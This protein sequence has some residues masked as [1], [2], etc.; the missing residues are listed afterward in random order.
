MNEGKSKMTRAQQ[1]KP[2][3]RIVSSKQFVA[4][5]EPPD[6]LIDG[7]VQRGFIYSMTAR[8]GDGKT[9]VALSIAAAIGTGSPLGDLKMDRGRVVYFAG[10]NPDDVRMRWIAMGERMKFDVNKIP[11]HFVAGT[12]KISE[13][14]AAIARGVSSL[15]GVDA[16]FVDTSAAYFEG[17]NE[18]DNVEA[19]GHWRMLRRLTQLEGSPCVIV[20]CHPTKSA[21]DENLLPRGG[22]AAIAEVDGN[23]TCVKGAAFVTLHWQGKHRG[24]DFDPLRFAWSVVTCERLV[25][26]RGR[27]IPTV[28]A[29]CV[30]AADYHE[31]M[32][33]IRD[34]DGQM[35]EAMRDNPDASMT[36]LAKALGWKYRDG[37]PAKSRVQRVIK[38][39][40]RAKRVRKPESTGK[41]EIAGG[42]VRSSKRA[43]GA[44]VNG[45]V[46]RGT[47]SGTANE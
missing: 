23:L 39:L 17:K 47:K 38:R 45:H 40:E 14:M 25:D 35:I 1:S 44:I 5:F 2:K 3:L 19:G 12:G 41:Y 28:I 13:D 18:N 36:E 34:E 7:V 20:P 15:G 33:D 43:G 30:S 27:A 32:E 42:T 21:S 9:A 22:G 26:S 46:R 29:R 6:Y 24:P 37:S 10:E 4:D 11:V 8:T 16:I 31:E